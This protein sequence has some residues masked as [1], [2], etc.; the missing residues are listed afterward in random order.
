[1]AK[2]DLTEVIFEDGKF[3]YNPDMK[4]GVLKKLFAASNSG[5]L[6]TMMDAYTGIVVSWPYGGSPSNPED[7]DDLT[8]T[9]FM[10]LNEA[11]MGSLSDL[12]E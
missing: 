3:T 9:Q 7:W 4:M 12:G 1:M 6:G 10:K 2:L 5:D 8:R 11:L